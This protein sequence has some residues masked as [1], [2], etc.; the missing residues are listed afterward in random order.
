[1]FEVHHVTFFKFC[2][3]MKIVCD[4][5]R[6]Q[7]V[8]QCL[9]EHQRIKCKCRTKMSCQSILTNSRYLRFTDLFFIQATFH[10]VPSKQTLKN[11]LIDG[12]R[13]NCVTS[14]QISRLFLFIHDSFSSLMGLFRG[15]KG[16]PFPFEGS[17][18]LTHSEA[19]ITWNARSPPQINSLG[20]KDFV[21]HP[22]YAKKTAGRKNTRPIERPHILC[23]YSMQNIRLNSDKVMPSF[24]LTTQIRNFTQQQLTKSLV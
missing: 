21:T 1:M 24:E 16:K 2:R 4:L 9:P 19:N 17:Q 18:F 3:L 6:R 13:C 12:M 22:L 20:F 11:T 15:G 8:R 10:H 14:L 7:Q 23:A 5:L